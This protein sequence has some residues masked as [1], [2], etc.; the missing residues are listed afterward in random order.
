MAYKAVISFDCEQFTMKGVTNLIFIIKFKEIH[1]VTFSG[2]VDVV[3]VTSSEWLRP[4]FE[5]RVVNG[6]IYERGAAG[7]KGDIT[8]MLS[9]TNKLIMSQSQ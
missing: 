5:G 3:P 1:C 9:A 4:L 7:I 2:H 6:T 8:A